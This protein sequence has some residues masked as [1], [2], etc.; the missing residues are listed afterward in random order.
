M[1]RLLEEEG[2]SQTL[3]TLFDDLPSPNQRCHVSGKTTLGSI[4]C[5]D[6]WDAC[7]TAAKVMI[8]RRFSI[9]TSIDFAQPDDVDE[10]AYWPKIYDRELE[11]STTKG[12]ERIRNMSSL[13]DRTRKKEKSHGRPAKKAKGKSKGCEGLGGEMGIRADS[14]LPQEDYGRGHTQNSYPLYPS[15][16]GFFGDS[17]NGN[18]ETGVKRAQVLDRT[19]SIN[20]RPGS[21]TSTAEMVEQRVATS[22]SQDPATVSYEVKEKENSM[23]AGTVHH[24]SSSE[25]TSLST[26]PASHVYFTGSRDLPAAVARWLSTT[27]P[28]LERGS[29][30]AGFSLP[31]IRRAG[32]ARMRIEITSLD[33]GIADN[34]LEV[35]DSVSSDECFSHDTINSYGSA[36][37]M[38]GAA[39]GNDGDRAESSQNTARPTGDNFTLS[40]SH[41]SSLPIE[42]IGHRKN[43]EDPG[44]EDNGGP[45]RKRRQFSSAAKDAGGLRFACPY[46]AYEPVAASQCCRPGPNNKQKGGCDGIVRVK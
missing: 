25:A 35:T 33:Y 26:P 1:Y 18:D 15:S 27:R 22:A 13:P 39:D 3:S 31:K 37:W 8:P 45:P 21:T 28:Q 46:Q 23:D 36:E 12:K 14:E 9:D 43:D 2:G 5:R 20:A 38:D 7:R 19:G 40:S 29:Q 30:M 42:M 24:R 16:P 10:D 6:D 11:T 44:K 32:V 4:G 41:Q 34:T 17:L